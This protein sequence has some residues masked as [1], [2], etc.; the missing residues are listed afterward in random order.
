MERATYGDKVVKTPNIDQLAKEGIRYT[1]VFTTAGVCAP[2]RAA[3]VTGMYQTSIGAQHMRTLPGGS[4]AKKDSLI[5]PYSA[6]IPDYVKCF[7]EYLRMAGYYCTNNEN[8]IT[9]SKHR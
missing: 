7:Q 9:S 3:I 8:R 5:T 6:V 4:G 2:S 1:N